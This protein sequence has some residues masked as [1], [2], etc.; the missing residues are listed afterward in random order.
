[1]YTLFQGTVATMALQTTDSN[2]SVSQGDAFTGVSDA[3]FISLTTA[4]I[5]GI[6]SVVLLDFASVSES[7]V[8][9]FSLIRLISSVWTKLRK[10]VMVLVCHSSHE[11]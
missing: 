9:H 4:E 2:W 1:M 8:L 10:N 7:P 3:M 5:V 11:W 6:S